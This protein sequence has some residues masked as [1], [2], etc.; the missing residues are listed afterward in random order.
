M[1]I[2]GKRVIVKVADV[3]REEQTASG[4]IVVKN[5][6]NVK[7]DRGT[8]IAF[9]DIQNIAEG[10]TIVFDPYSVSEVNLY[11]NKYIVVNEEHIIAKL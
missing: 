11:D 3:V 7:P 10:D 2:F 6:E 5:V 8:V 4:F 1:T 9:G